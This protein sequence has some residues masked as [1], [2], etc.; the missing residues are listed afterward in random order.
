MSTGNDFNI[1]CPEDCVVNPFTA[2]E[3]IDKDCQPLPSQAEITDIILGHPE[4][5]VPPA[6]WTVAGAGGWAD[7]ID[8]ASAGGIK[9]KRFL[10]SGSIGEPERTAIEMSA[11][12]KVNG[13]ATYT[14]EAIFKSIPPLT[15]D[16]LRALQCGVLKP[17]LWYIDAG[18]KMYGKNDGIETSDVSVVFPHELG[19]DSY[20]FATL[21]LSWEAQTDPDRID[22]PI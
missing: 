3:T 18:G 11:F 15:Y 22:S 17:K 10:V 1:T 8:N 4:D 14:I 21:R 5:A 12:R 7:V 20:S 13:V 6:D 2:V 16:F 9:L 19:K